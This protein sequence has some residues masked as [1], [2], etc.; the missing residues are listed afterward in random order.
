MNDNFMNN[1]K[2][3]EFEQYNEFNCFHEKKNYFVKVKCDT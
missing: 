1:M 2:H 3:D